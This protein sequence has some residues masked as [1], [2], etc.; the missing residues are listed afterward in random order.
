MKNARIFLLLFLI[1]PLI[2]GAKPRFVESELQLNTGTGILYG[3]LC[4][5]KAKKAIPVALIIAG[6]GPTDRN[7]N[8][9]V[10]KNDALKKIAHG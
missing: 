8:N 5:P 6:S 2:S 3:T 7:G 4:V 1:A 10:M 9:P